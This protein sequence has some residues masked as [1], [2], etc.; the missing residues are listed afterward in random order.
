MAWSLMLSSTEGSNLKIEYDPD[1]DSLYIKLRSDPAQ[2]S[3]EVEPGIVFD[4]D[5]HGKVIGI[6]IEH[7]SNFTDVTNLPRSQPDVAPEAPP[8]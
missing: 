8:T 3:Q 6:D 7:A 5:G 2:E 4:F 1:T